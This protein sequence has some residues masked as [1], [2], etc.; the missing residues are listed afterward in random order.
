MACPVTA[1]ETAPAADTGDRQRAGGGA[2]RGADT[3][4]RAGD[5]ELPVAVA[6]T[7]FCPPAVPATVNV[8]VAVP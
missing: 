3:G 1:P 8:P 7:V 5:G 6:V 4:R 2:G